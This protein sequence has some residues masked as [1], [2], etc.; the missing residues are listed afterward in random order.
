M[1]SYRFLIK[2]ILTVSIISI[3]N[4]NGFSQQVMSLENALSLTLKE[5]ISIK[6]ISNETDQIKNYEKFKYHVSLKPLV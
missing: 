4:L 2:F 6:I 3:L 1:K 5:N